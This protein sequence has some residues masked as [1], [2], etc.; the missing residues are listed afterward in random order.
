MILLS[1]A[2]QIF[3]VLCLIQVLNNQLLTDFKLIH[4]D[5]FLLNPDKNTYVNDAL[6][7]FSCIDNFFVINELIVNVKKISIIDSGVNHSDHKP[8]YGFVDISLD[9]NVAKS[10][11]NSL[12]A[13]YNSYSLRWDKSNLNDYY[14]VS[15]DLLSNIIFDTNLSHCDHNCKSCLHVDIINDY[16]RRIVHALIHAEEKTIPHVPHRALR[17]FR[18]DELDE[19]KQKSLF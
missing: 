2:T 18:N 8:I 19:L 3:H 16:Y 6:G 14:N 12:R 5:N 9:L 7:H 17:P 10:G 1:L 11:K 15:R 13:G 4:C